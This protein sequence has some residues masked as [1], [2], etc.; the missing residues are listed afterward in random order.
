MRLRHRKIPV[1]RRLLQLP[2]ASC[3][4]RWPQHWQSLQPSRRGAGGGRR[5]LLSSRC[6]LWCG[7]TLTSDPTCRLAPRREPTRSFRLTA[8]GWCT[9]RKGGSLPGGSI[10][11]TPLSLQERRGHMLLSSRRTGSGSL[12]SRRESCKR[13]RWRAARQSPCATRQLARGGSWGEDGNIIAALSL[14]GGLSRIPSAGGPPTPVTD[15]QNGEVTHRWP[16]ILPGGKAVLFT[17]STIGG[18]RR[19]PTSK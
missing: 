16:Q 12:S 10:S 8:R 1:Q 6:G 18:V 3:C 5:G 15:L 2:R 9:C 19:E 13:F 7:W 17:A 4:G 11:P 14:T